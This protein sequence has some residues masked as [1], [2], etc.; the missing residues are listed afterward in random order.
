MENHWQTYANSKNRRIKLFL[1]AII[2]CTVVCCFSFFLVWNES[3]TGVPFNDP[4]LNL[5]S[6]IDFSRITSI[7]TLAPVFFSFFF[8]LRRPESTVYFFLAIMIVTIFRAFTLYI[9]VL[10]PPAKII[11][12]SDPIIESLFY[13]GDILLRDLFFSGHTANLIVVALLSDTLWVKRTILGCAAIVGCLLMV[14]HVHYSIDVFAAPFFA[15]L[16]YKSSIYLGNKY[17][18]NEMV[19]SQRTGSLKAELGLEKL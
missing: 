11:P 13:Q 2:S 3:R 17:F 18:L 1:L 19:E 6:P 8:I 7:F 15:I 5:F 9:I 14:Q 10:E 4:V 16:A 12:L